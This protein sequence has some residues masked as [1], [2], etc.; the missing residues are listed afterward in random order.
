MLE[1]KM[2]KANLRLSGVEHLPFQISN[3]NPKSMI[4]LFDKSFICLANES[5]KNVVA[6]IYSL[7]WQNRYEESS[8]IGITGI[9][10]KVSK[11]TE[12]YYELQT[13][14][15]E[16]KNFIG[17]HFYLVSGPLFDEVKKQHNLKAPGLEPNFKEDPDGFTC[18]LSF[19]ISNFS[20][21]PHKDDDASSITFFMWIPIKQ[22]T[23]QFVGENF[24]VKGGEFVFPY[25]SC[26][27]NVSGFNGIVECSWKATFS[28][29][30]S[31]P[32]L[33][34]N[35]LASFPRRLKRLLKKSNR[36]SMQKILIK[37]T[38]M[39]KII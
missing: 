28:P 4:Q 34:L 11:D 12:A 38:D 39:N 17:K 19:T 14:F 10:A 27:I 1:R 8:K 3:P 36:I 2:F 37:A 24:E 21:K 26:G 15:P 9:A 5:P 35:H 23:C 22:T 33:L 13:H 16:Q 18:H 29:N 32:I 6:V 7:G 25:D 20:N 31:F 30:S